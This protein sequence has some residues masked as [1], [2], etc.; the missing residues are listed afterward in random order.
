MDERPQPG[1]AV[2]FLVVQVGV[3]RYAIDTRQ[4]VEVLPLVA[5]SQVARAPEAVAGILVYRGAPVPVVDLSQLF[6]GRPA[7]HRMSTRVVVVRYEDE[8]G[9]PCLL[10][11]VAERVTETMR[12]EFSAF[13]DSGVR[14]H[15]TPFL[16]PV[17]TDARGLV[18]RVD[19]ARL[20]GARP[21]T[22]SSSPPGEREWLS[23]TSRAS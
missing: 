15:G 6:E 12:R 4:I 19:V 11:L 22:K 2:L 14:N 1:G 20:L 8:S 23:L 3:H 17:I 9:A 13:V 21:Q 18:Q 5:I 16:G 10:G 7:E